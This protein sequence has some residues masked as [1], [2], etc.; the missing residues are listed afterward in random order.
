[1]PILI[2]RRFKWNSLSKEV[3]DWGCDQVD[4]GDEV[5]DVSE[6][7]VRARAAWKRPFRPS[8]RALVCQEDQRK[9][10]RSR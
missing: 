8:R 10:M 3:G 9:R 1:M 7:L 6:P 4:H 2:L 5:R